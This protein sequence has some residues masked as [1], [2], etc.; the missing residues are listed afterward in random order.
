MKEE[1]KDD[2]LEIK[3]EQK[4]DDFETKYKDH[5]INNENVKSNYLNKN[6]ILHLSFDIFKSLRLNGLM[7]E[8]K[9]KFI[10]E[11]V[12]KETI[13][14]QPED[15]NFSNQIVNHLTNFISLKLFDAE[16]LIIHQLI[17]DITITENNEIKIICDFL[18]KNFDFSIDN[19]NNDFQ[20]RYIEDYLKIKDNYNLTSI[21]MEKLSKKQKRYLLYKLKN[22]NNQKL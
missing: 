2:N 17:E 6:D 5:F 13:T 20:I 3:N 9:I 4:L 19:M 12:N 8:L 21:E 18:V 15:N 1:K 10:S 16:E 7:D 11:N 22:K 14:I